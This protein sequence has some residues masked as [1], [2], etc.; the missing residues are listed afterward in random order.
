METVVGNN[1]VKEECTKPVKVK[2]VFPKWEM[3]HRYTFNLTFSLNEIHWDPA[4]ENWIDDEA[5]K[6]TIDR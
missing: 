5:G 6:I 1:V 4:V 2:D 3:G